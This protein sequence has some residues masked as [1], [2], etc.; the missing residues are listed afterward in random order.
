MMTI[1]DG[2]HTRP[3]PISR[4][5]LRTRS[6]FS[7]LMA[8]STRAITIC[9]GDTRSYPEARA[10]IFS[11]N[12]IPT[13]VPPQSPAGCNQRRQ[14]L[15]LHGPVFRQPHESRVVL[16]AGAVSYTHLRAHE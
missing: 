5:L 8:R 16:E 13:A 3:T 15:V 1:F 11:A 7:W 14:V 6:A 10:R 12:V 2:S 4:K 9:S